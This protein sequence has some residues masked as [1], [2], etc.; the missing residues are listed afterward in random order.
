MTTPALD[1]SHLR[2]SFSRPGS[3]IEVL[4]D[5]S[6]TLEPGATLAL[7][8]ESGS[9][10]ST[11]LHLIS[12]LDRPDSGDIRVA[13]QNI[14]ALPDHGLARLRRER[15]ALIFQ[16]YNLIPSL[17]VAD[18]LAFHARMAGRRDDA[19]TN[20]LTERLG[21]SGLS[22]RMPDELSG[23]QRQRVAIGRAMAL[24]PALLLAD[25]PT[26]NLDEGSAD[27]VI[28]AMLDLVAETGCALLLVT[29]SERIASRMSRRLHLSHG[30]VRPA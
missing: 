6:F 13:G 12:G 26:G 10:K 29:H 5:T 18:N 22:D 9:G 2:K 11:L 21:L 23:G 20:A 1:V 16:Q 28:A 7:T 8:G 17:N 14:T 24:R 19:W 3:D 4:S 15:I 30:K 27:V 25:E